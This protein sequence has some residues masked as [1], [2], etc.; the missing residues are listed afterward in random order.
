[1]ENWAVGG[2]LLAVGDEDGDEAALG[3]LDGIEAD[4]PGV[5]DEPGTADSELLQAART[6]LISAS[7]THL[8][9]APER[10]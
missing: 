4:G 8:R 1:M 9:Q 5:T 3:G 2:P 7:G 6:R 10:T